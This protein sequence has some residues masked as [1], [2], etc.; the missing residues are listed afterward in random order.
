MGFFSQRFIWDFV[1]EDSL[2]RISFTMPYLSTESWRNS[3]GTDYVYDVVISV[4]DSVF[5]CVDTFF[6]SRLYIIVFP[7]NI[8]TS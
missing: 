7:E 8:L 1:T 4:S 6:S 5:V 2:N 3:H